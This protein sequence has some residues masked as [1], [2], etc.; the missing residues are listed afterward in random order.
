MLGPDHPG[1]LTTR[2]Q[3]AQWRGVAGDAAAA[4]DAYEQLLADYLRVLGPDH[5]DTLTTR[6]VLAHWRGRRAESASNNDRS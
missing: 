6:N 5:P 1:T 4:A 3:L 2:G